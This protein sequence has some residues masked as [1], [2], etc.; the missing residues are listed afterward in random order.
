M[1]FCAVYKKNENKSSKIFRV[2]SVYQ[3]AVKQ[4]DKHSKHNRHNYT[5]QLYKQGFFQICLT[6]TGGQ[7]PA[8]FTSCCGKA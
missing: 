3:L 5:G 6:L 8:N 2:G 1:L 4:G 7:F